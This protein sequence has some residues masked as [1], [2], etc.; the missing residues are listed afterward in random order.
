M[1]VA[2][3]RAGGSLAD[4]AGF[5]GTALSLAGPFCENFPLA[6]A[7]KELDLAFGTGSGADS[8]FAGVADL[9]L[10]CSSNFLFHGLTFAIGGAPSVPEGALAT[11]SALAACATGSAFAA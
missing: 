4:F 5:A 6:I 8:L 2:I 9:F 11:G 10:F 1:P 7:P 3:K